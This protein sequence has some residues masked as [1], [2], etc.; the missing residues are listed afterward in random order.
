MHP[1]FYSVEL[2]KEI[3]KKP[4]HFTSYGCINMGIQTVQFY[5]TNA[6]FWPTSYFN[7]TVLGTPYICWQFHNALCANTLPLQA[8]HIW[9]V[10]FT[11]VNK[12]VSWQPV[13]IVLGLGG[14]WLLLRNILSVTQQPVKLITG[15]RQWHPQ[16]QRL[17]HTHT[18]MHTYMHALVAWHIALAACHSDI[19][20]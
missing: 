6:V 15:Q 3:G 4:F 16:I 20:W 18:Y 10:I 7:V 14:R 13:N 9:N 2:C 11:I 1:N 17:T 19:K 12:A 5:G 8:I